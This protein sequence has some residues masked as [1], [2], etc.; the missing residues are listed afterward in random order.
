PDGDALANEVAGVLDRPLT[1]PAA[2]Q[3]SLLFDDDGSPWH[4][5]CVTEA[6]DRPALLHA[7]TTAFAAA[8]A[9]VHSARVMTVGGAA[10]DEFELT[11][12]NG[13]KLSDR[14]KEAIRHALADGVKPR[15]GWRR[16]RAADDTEP[17]E[18]V[19]ATVVEPQPVGHN[20][21]IPT[22]Y[23]PPE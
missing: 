12:R 18:T 4:T 23:G 19:K 14:A 6:P 22:S 17:S 2:P 5:L 16:R 3:V 13:R 1:S 15:R 20:G 11:D 7:L 9:S 21:E 10:V 8:G